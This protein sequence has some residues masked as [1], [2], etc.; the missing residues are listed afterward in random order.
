M[1]WWWGSFDRPVLTHLSC[2]G[3]A[4]VLKIH[5]YILT[6]IMNRMERQIKIKETYR[7]CSFDNFCK[8]W[9]SAVA[10]SG[11]FHKFIPITMELWVVHFFLGLLQPFKHNLMGSSKKAGNSNMRTVT[12]VV[13]LGYIIKIL[14]NLRIWRWITWFILLAKADGKGEYL[15]TNLVE[16]SQNRIQWCNPNTPL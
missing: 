12:Q 3:L 13:I 10:Q 16:I 1:H 15:S 5:E 4:L 7:I 2:A 6:A 11:L 14:D 9:V 8:K